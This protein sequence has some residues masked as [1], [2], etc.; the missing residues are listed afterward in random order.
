MV[1]ESLF[2]SSLPPQE[3]ESDAV[4]P[5]H[6]LDTTFP[7]RITSPASLGLCHRGNRGCSLVQTQTAPSGSGWVLTHLKEGAGQ[8]FTL[9]RTMR[10]C[11][12]ADGWMFTLVCNTVLPRLNWRKTLVT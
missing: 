6:L 5:V 4:C 3:P 11:Q 7:R 2:E 8:W 1:L 9:V 12:V 10:V